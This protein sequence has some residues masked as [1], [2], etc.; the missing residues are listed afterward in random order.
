[1]FVFDKRLT[2]EQAINHKM[3]S[4]A[5]FGFLTK[6]DMTG[7]T[8]YPPNTYAKDP[9]TAAATA[10]AETAGT[11]NAVA[12]LTRVRW[13]LGATDPIIIEGL[14]PIGL[15]QI[16]TGMLYT[17]LTDIG[18]EFGVKV[19]EYDPI[20]AAG[21]KYYAAFD[22]ST[23]PLKGKIQKSGDRELAIELDD[24]EDLSIQDNSFY[25]FSMKIVPYGM[26]QVITLASAAVA[27]ITKLWGRTNP[28]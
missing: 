24:N 15:K 3:S 12:L 5:P 8:P 10:G 18:V 22:A 13:D 11:A 28:T 16:M 6:L 14:I 21:K 26:N 4:K 25:P 19:F 9:T 23:T 1:M 27:G 2:P 7:A 17:G 20:A